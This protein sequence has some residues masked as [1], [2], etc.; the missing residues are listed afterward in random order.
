VRVEQKQYSTGLII[1]L[2]CE[3]E[4]SLVRNV[5]ELKSFNVI[6]RF[7]HITLA[8]AVAHGHKEVKIKLHPLNASSS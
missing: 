4:A 5:G 8:G 7:I 3:T 1:L 2:V 6:P